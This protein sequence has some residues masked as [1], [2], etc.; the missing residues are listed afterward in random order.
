VLLKYYSGS[1]IFSFKLY[2]SGFLESDL[3]FI[4]LIFVLFW[5]WLFFGLRYLIEAHFSNF[6]LG[7]VSGETLAVLSY[8]SV[9]ILLFVG[10]LKCFFFFF[11]FLWS[12]LSSFYSYY[13]FGNNFAYSE[14]LGLAV[15][16]LLIFA[17]NLLLREVFYF[18][19][20]SRSELSALVYSTFISWDYFLCT[21]IG[22]FFGILFAQRCK[23]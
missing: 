15:Y 19:W 3:L 8:F 13:L 22:H 14:G 17:K 5:L 1:M 10:L 12:Y 4:F 18:C 2:Y 21:N 20:K 7:S 6:I 23:L 11:L 9:N 16:G